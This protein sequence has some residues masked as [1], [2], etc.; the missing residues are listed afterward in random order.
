MRWGSDGD[1]SLTSD[2]DA[3]PYYLEAEPN[4]PMCRLRPGKAVASK[5]SGSPRDP[6]ANFTAS[7]KRAS[8]FDLCEQGLRERKGRVIRFIWS[9]R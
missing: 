4:S 9:F 6:E 8:S 2:P 5:R 7:Q 3:S 1:P